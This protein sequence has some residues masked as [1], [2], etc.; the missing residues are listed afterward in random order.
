[1]NPEDKER[2]EKFLTGRCLVL[3]C[4]NAPYTDPPG[5]LQ[6]LNDLIGVN[7]SL[8]ESTKVIALH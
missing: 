2:K 6:N 1:M 8:Q 5:A 7:Q 3:N 4:T